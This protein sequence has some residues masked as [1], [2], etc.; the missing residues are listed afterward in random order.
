MR[1]AGSEP[2]KRITIVGPTHPYT[3]GI[4]QHNTRLAHELTD[5]GEEVAIESWRAQYPGFLYRGTPRVPRDRP[6][7]EPF[8]T[9]RE[10]LAWYS[11]AS[12]IAAGWRARRADALVLTIV[13][14]FH[15]V[16][17]SFMLA[18]AGHHATRVAMVHNVLPHEEGLADRLLMRWILRRMD[19]VIVHSDRQAQLARSLGIGGNRV[20][21]AELPFPGIAAAEHVPP[22]PFSQNGDTVR[23]LFF[24]TVRPYKGLDNLIRALALV[25]KAELTVA[26]DFWEPVDHYLELARDAGVEHRVH[27]DPGYVDTTAIPGLFEHS[28]AL[29]MPY[30][31]GTASI[32][33]DLASMYARP[34][35]VTDVGTLAD[36]VR[37]GV[38]GFVVEADN[39][40]ALAEALN[41][42]AEP[43]VLARLAGQVNRG[44][45]RQTREWSTYVSTVQAAL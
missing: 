43:G 23:L 9:V 15:A 8:G 16:P 22:L 29:V 42:L 13:T 41:R 6:E 1:R 5:A 28:D 32:V 14:P 36:G 34:V 39:V 44:Q 12:W 31:S 45:D 27:L 11:P 25:P 18:A 10:K 21:V 40:P 38:D 35:I 26:G 19:C 20:Q 37:D 3:G 2:G 24:G 7:L 17:Y 4:A 33:S 30:R